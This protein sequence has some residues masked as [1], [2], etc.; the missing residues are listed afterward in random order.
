MIF[1][2]L[3]FDVIVNNQVYQMVCNDGAPLQDLLQ[4]IK[5]LEAEVERIIS[6]AEAKKEAENAVE[7]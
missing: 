3:T 1:R 2:K 5:S 7:S 6:E 4:A